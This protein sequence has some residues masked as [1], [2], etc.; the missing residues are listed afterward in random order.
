MAVRNHLAAAQT[1]SAV[2]P[3][4]QPEVPNGP[5]AVPSVTAAQTGPA[6]AS[7]VTAAEE[8]KRPVFGVDYQK[9]V[10]RQGQY[11]EIGRAHV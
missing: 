4:P 3:N 1:D 7:N 10:A 9:I 11:L 2:T 6:A 5:V 8:A